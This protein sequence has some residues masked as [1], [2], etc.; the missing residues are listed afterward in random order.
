MSPAYSTEDRKLVAKLV[1]RVFERLEATPPNVIDELQNA[2]DFQSSDRSISE[3]INLIVTHDSP[4]RRGSS[5]KILQ[6]KP[7]QKGPKNRL[8]S[9]GT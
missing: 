5:S 6:T 7:G 4:S 8:L 9:A 2:P 1:D 3:V